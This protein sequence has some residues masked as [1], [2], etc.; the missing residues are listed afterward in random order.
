MLSLRA[1]LARGITTLDRSLFTRTL[2]LAAATVHDPRNIAK[3][4][5]MLN[6]GNEM[7]GWERLESC[8]DDPVEK[9]KKC[10]LLK[11]TVKADGR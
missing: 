5:K 1:P 2:N 7:L 10:L 3:Y 4:R 11:P 8:R 9:G 6:K